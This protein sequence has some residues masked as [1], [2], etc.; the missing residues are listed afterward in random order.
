MVNL[1]M[2]VVIHDLKRQG[3]SINAIARK[4]GLDRKTVRN[5][6]QRGL[7]GPLY[8]P[9][10]PRPRLIDLYEDDLRERTTA[11]EG[12]SGRRLYRDITALGYPGGYTAV[13]DCLREIRGQLP[14]RFERRFETPPGRQT[15]V[16]FAA[17]MVE[18]TDEP[19][20]RRKLWLFSCVLGNSRW[21]WGRFC[22]NQ[23]L[24]TMLRCHI[25]AFEAAGGVPEETLYD[26][27]KTAVLGEE[28]DG[29]IHLQPVPGRTPEPRWRRTAGLPRVPDKNEG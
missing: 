10:A 24:E 7:E 26:R 6:L 12:L 22:P 28:A 20:V 4:M 21:L 27:M 2:I 19:G 16:D 9:R 5:Y 13:T 11:C 17:F 15:Q 23:K 1:R 3:L 25:M 18:F 8:G 29:T 14:R